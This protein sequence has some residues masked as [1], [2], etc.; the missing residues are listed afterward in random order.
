[1]W[2]QHSDRLAR[3]DGLAADHLAEVFFEMRRAGVSLRSVQ[4]DAWR[5]PRR[6]GRGRTLASSSSRP[7]PRLSTTSTGG[8]GLARA[9]IGALR[10][11]ESERRD[12]A[13]WR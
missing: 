5:R 4:D 8:P 6:A 11:G 13:A 12:S 9:A 10:A 1:L 2:V 7:P 3:G